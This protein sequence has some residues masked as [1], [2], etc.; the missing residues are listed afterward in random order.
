MTGARFE[1]SVS[2]YGCSTDTR[3]GGAVYIDYANLEFL[4]QDA[5]YDSNSVLNNV[6]PFLRHGFWRG[7]TLAR[8]AGNYVCLYCTAVLFPR[9]NEDRQR[10]WRSHCFS[11]CTDTPA[12]LPI[13]GQG[14]S[15]YCVCF[16]PTWA[17][18]AIVPDR[19]YLHNSPRKSFCLLQFPAVS[20]MYRR[21]RKRDYRRHPSNVDLHSLLAANMSNQPRSE[22]NLL[23]PPH[24]PH[25][26]YVRAYLPLSLAFL[27]TNG[28]VRRH[29]QVR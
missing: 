8:S 23:R 4:P 5:T 21:E 20:F 2:F 11:F 9:T 6:R 18:R 7:R 15:K 22:T 10:T 13:T 14:S 26:V 16:L 17:V 28:T 29:L 27:S 12:I 25:P 1:K 24:D 3:D 19:P